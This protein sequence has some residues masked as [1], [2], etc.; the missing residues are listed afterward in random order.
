MTTEP[1]SWGNVESIP[2]ELITVLYGPPG[3]GKTICACRLG[4]RNLLL[5]SEKSHVSISNFPELVKTTRVEVYKSFSGL[6]SFLR[7]VFNGDIDPDHVII[8]TYTDTCEMKLKEQSQANIFNS[9]H[10]DINSLEDY[11]LLK[12]HMKPFIKKLTKLSVSVTLIAYDR[13]PNAQ[14]YGKG[15][16]LTRPDVPFRVFQIVNSFANVV[17]YMHKVRT[18]SGKTERVILTSSSDTH[19]AK[20]HLIMPDLVSDDQF[21]KTITDWKSN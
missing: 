6:N 4:K 8:D 3:I 21:V 14:D 5:T 12:E 20:S 10:P 7:K 15:D 9:K 11:Q 1:E 17:G 2:K 18:K 13:V 16:T 19:V